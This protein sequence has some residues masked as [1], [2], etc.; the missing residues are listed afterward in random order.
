MAETNGGVARDE[1]DRQL[2]EAEPPAHW[3]AVVRALFFVEQ[4][5]WQ[6]A[7]DIVE[8]A[9]SRLIRWV[10]AHLH[11]WEGDHGNAAYWYRR[12]DRPVS[13]VSLDDERALLRDTVLPVAG[14]SPR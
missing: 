13:S 4:G 6:R 14:G 7:H 3:P 11:R 8:H 2:T 10:H 12:A 1:F 5:D 9:D